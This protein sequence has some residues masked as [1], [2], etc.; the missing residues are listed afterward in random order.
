MT[1][2]H[3]PARPLD[4]DG[5]RA[6]CLG[7]YARGTGGALSVRGPGGPGGGRGSGGRGVPRGHGLHGCGAAACDRVKGSACRSQEGGCWSA[8]GWCAVACA[9]RGSRRH[10]LPPTRWPASQRGR[11]PGH[12]R[13]SAHHAT[14]CPG[15]RRIGQRLSLYNHRLGSS[16][17]HYCTAEVLPAYGLRSVLV[18]WR[19]GRRP[20]PVRCQPCGPVL[21]GRW[22]GKPAGPSRCRRGWRLGRRSSQRHASRAPPRRACLKPRLSP[23]AA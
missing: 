4:V 13:T 9:S 5:G 14:R 15:G 7:Q 2:Q 11:R 17:T 3:S 6:A 18:A 20:W 16:G 10:T 19:R 12:A 1:A 22:L 21:R 8:V 23:I